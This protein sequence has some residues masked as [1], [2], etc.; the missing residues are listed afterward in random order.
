MIISPYIGF[1]VDTDY[2]PEK[3][4][5]FKLYNQQIAH[6][7]FFFFFLPLNKKKKE[8]NRNF[9]I[10]FNLLFNYARYS[11]GLRFSYYYY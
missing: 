11:E 3:T 9:R 7:F 2:E 10:Q 4:E 5:F 1:G 8:R 6:V